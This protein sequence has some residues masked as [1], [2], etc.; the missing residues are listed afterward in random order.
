MKR[1]GELTTSYHIYLSQISNYS[2]I[3]PILQSHVQNQDPVGKAYCTAKDFNA[4][5]SCQLQGFLGFK[6]SQ[7]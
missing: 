4:T 7:K 3:I 2:N 5:V 6:N 1:I